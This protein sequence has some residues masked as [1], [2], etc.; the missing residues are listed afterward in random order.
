MISS[1]KIKISSN[2]V[3]VKLLQR[4]NEGKAILK[5]QD[6]LVTEYLFLLKKYQDVIESF[7]QLK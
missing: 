2:K 4:F 7:G 5:L 1:D 6:I 3:K